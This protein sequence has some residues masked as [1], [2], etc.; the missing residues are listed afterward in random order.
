MVSI[1]LIF[2]CSSSYFLWIRFIF[3]FQLFFT[4]NKALLQR[5]R[6]FKHIW[7]GK[8][9]IYHLSYKTRRENDFVYIFNPNTMKEHMEGTSEL[10]ILIFQHW[11]A[12]REMEGIK[13]WILKAT[14][15]GNCYKPHWQM[16]IK[17]HN[18]CKLIPILIMESYKLIHSF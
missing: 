8:K 7:W 2:S 15:N 6:W 4:E 17:H 11:L 16:F 1:S 13:S 5:E 14:W 18:R 10:L 9:E 12:N 3:I